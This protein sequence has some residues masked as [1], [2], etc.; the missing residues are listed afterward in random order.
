MSPTDNYETLRVDTRKLRPGLRL[1]PLIESPLPDLTDAEISD[2]IAQTLIEQDAEDSAT[3]LE[4]VTQ[5]VACGAPSSM[6]CADTDTAAGP[7][8]TTAPYGR[9]HAAFETIAAPE[10]T[11]SETG[12]RRRR[13][14]RGL[15]QGWLGRVLIGLSALVVFYTWPWIIPT[16]I[17]G[18]IWLGLIVFIFVGMERIAAGVLWFYRWLEGRAPRRAERLRAGADRLAVR[19]DSLFD[20]LPG[21]WTEGLYMPDFSREALIDDDKDDAP[22][23]F[24]RLAGQ[25]H[26]G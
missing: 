25:S 24:D 6:A 17:I 12:T 10:E 26:H 3:A 15:R 14:P 7:Q 2:M 4:A 20:R 9:S 22:D 1:D 21:R 18:A 5:A 16:L 8:G 19:L 13:G 11:D 23:P